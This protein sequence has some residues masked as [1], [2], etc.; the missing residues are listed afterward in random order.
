MDAVREALA[1]DPFFDLVPALRALA[2]DGFVT[3]TTVYPL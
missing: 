1:E 3:M 2:A